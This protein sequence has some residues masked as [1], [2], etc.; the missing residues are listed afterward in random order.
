MNIKFSSILKLVTKYVKPDEAPEI[1]FTQ[2]KAAELTARHPIKDLFSFKWFDAD[3]NLMF[4]ADGPSFAV[5]FMFAISPLNGA[6]VD[7]EEQLEALASSVPPDTIIQFS[8]C[9]SSN[10]DH[11]VDAWAATRLKIGK[12]DPD[13]LKMV[14]NRSDFFKI[15]ARGPSLLPD[16]RMHPRAY[17]YFVSVRIPFK[18]SLNDDSE[19]SAFIESTLFTRKT[20]EGILA[21]ASMSSKVLNENEVKYVLRELIN[22]HLDP[23]TR[24]A[25]QVNGISVVDDIIDNSSRM[26]VLSNGG[27]EF[28]TM[29]EDD[30]P[31]VVT[32]LTVD[33]TPKALYLPA[34]ELTLGNPLSMNE[35]ITCPYFAYTIIHVLHPDDAKDEL[36]TKFGLL[37]KQT[38]TDSAWFRAM[39][40]SLFERKDRAERLLS[41][42]NNGKRLVRAYTGIN[43]YT[44]KSEVRSQSEYVKGLYRNAGFRLSEE[45]YISLPVFIASIP[46]QYSPAMDPPNKGLQRAWL[47][48]SLNAVSMLQVQGDWS[49]THKTKEGVLLVSRAGQLATFNLFESE[50]NYNFVVVAE[51]GSGKSFFTNEIVLDIRARGGLIRIIDVGN[52]YL[53]FVETNGGELISFDPDNPRS[54]NPFTGIKEQKDLDELVPMLQDL[55]RLMAFPLTPE[56]QTPMFQYQLLDKAITEAWLQKRENCELFDV[57]TWLQNYDDPRAQDLAIQLEPY[58]HGRY[59]IWFSGKRSIDLDNP[60]IVLELEALKRDPNLQSVVLQMMMYQITQEMYLSSREILKLLI[61]DEAWDLFSGL[62]SGKFIET[63]FRRIRK[64]NGSA[65]VITQRYKDFDASA[66]A[67][68][69]FDNSA[70]QFTLSQ[71]SGI[72]EAQEA[73]Y[74]PKGDRILEMVSS[75]KSGNGYSEI[76]VQRGR[77]MGIFRFITDRHTYYT[78]TTNPKDTNKL[79]A[80]VNAGL[81]MEEAIDKLALADYRQRWKS[82]ISE[83]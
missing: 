28:S 66:A 11:I 20:I 38:M 72:A 76:L 30:D 7:T 22:P 58:S 37:T 5:G 51:S 47:M 78:F 63:A 59:R 32:P 71:K 77:D 49:G 52:S 57:V 8:K 33:A 70:W 12:D 60:L 50:T 74:L 3:D 53:K 69:A 43:I 14:N 81:S 67:R 73:G 27:L 17:S 35:R 10:V 41:Q 55:L 62:K 24:E 16:T 54:L 19:Y 6:G 18:G 44:P 68:A 29:Q 61:I 21:S 79:N 36:A 80:E 75:V 2:A 26:R 1:P 39:M 23:H 48:S 65:G 31:I 15:T 56:E 82:F 13:I 45:S 34:M 83:D 25:E 4:I 9:S 46:M 64:Y 42:A 40:G